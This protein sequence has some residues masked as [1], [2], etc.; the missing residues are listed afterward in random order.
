MYCAQNSL[1]LISQL[2]LATRQRAYADQKRHAP[3]MADV[4][5]E[6]DSI[7]RIAISRIVSQEATVGGEL[8]HSWEFPG[9][10]A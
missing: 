10:C 1:R 7:D 3:G 8:N 5:L 9:Y 4:Q 2:G 6:H